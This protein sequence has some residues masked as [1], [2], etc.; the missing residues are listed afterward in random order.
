MAVQEV[1][2]GHPALVGA[3]GP[4]E[5]CSS[6]LPNQPITQPQQGELAWGSGQ[7]G[8]Q[9]G[10]PAGPSLATAVL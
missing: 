2:I 1:T 3:V 7:G 4:G 9:P 6:S 10:L 5:Q 8:L